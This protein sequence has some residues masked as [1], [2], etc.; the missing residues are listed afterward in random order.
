MATNMAAQS[1]IKTSIYNILIKNIFNHILLFCPTASMVYV[2]KH[3]SPK[4]Y[5]AK[6][7]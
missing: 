6:P 4:E 2:H 7:V 1:Q 5:N 3:N